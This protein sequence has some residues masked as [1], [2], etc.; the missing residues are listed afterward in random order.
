MI[1]PDRAAAALQSVRGLVLTGGEDVAPQRYG[2]SPHPRL[3]EVDA[4]RDAA[5]VA[6]IEA[7]RKRRLPILAICRR[8]QILNVRLAGKL[9]QEF[10]TERPGP[11]AATDQ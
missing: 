11:R 2:A 1:A 9:V 6:L 10:Q 4:D 3:G 5:E 8:I 7:A